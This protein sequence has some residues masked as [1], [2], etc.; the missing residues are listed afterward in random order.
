VAS[1]DAGANDVNTFI[2]VTMISAAAAIA[3]VSLCILAPYLIVIA[4]M[5][6]TMPPKVTPM[7]M[8]SSPVRVGSPVYAPVGG[9]GGS[10]RDD[11]L[12]GRGRRVSVTESPL[13]HAQGTG[14]FS[15]SSKISV[16]TGA[17]RGIV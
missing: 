3:V 12:P 8:R 13:H 14:G 15:S 9:V 7:M 16:N 11:V 10:Q 4:F 6:A 2:L 5:Q 17:A 1:S